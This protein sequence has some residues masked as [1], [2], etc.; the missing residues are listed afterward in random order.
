MAGKT[1][2]TIYFYVIS[3][4]AT[5]LI[6]IGIFNIINF[7]INSTQYDKYPLRYS[8][9]NCEFYPYKLEQYPALEE[10][11]ATP[12]AEMLLKQQ[13]AC[14]MQQA[15][16]RKQHQIEDLRNAI[17]FTSIGALLFLIHYPQAKKRT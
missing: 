15:E 2:A 5:I 10:K 7:V 11:V 14:F 13:R 17:A 16:D 3:A 9:G 1:I 8:Q 12:S 6:I 4:G